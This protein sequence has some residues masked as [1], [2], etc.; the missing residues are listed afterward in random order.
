MR[1]EKVVG[2]VKKVNE[3]TSEA[4]EEGGKSEKKTEMGNK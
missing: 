3:V 4:K 2:R 1:E